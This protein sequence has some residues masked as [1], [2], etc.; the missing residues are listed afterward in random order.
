MQAESRVRINRPVE[1]VFAFLS[2]P[3]NHARFVPGVQDFQ[4]TSGTMAEGA[5]AVGTRRV[6]G[7]VRRLPYRISVYQP[8]RVLG[9][10]T[11]MG[12]LQ[13]GATYYLDSEGAY[14]TRVRFVVEGGFRGLL[15]VADGLLAR[16]LTRDAATV[17][18]NLKAILES[19]RADASPEGPV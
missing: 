9:M 17:G 18:R 12:P 14:V 7:M 4:V 13:G 3:E 10:T 8:N 11:Q 1:D 16:T 2:R 19:E 6:L 15:R 5:N